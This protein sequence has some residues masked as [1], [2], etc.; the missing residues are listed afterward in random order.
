MVSCLISLVNL[1]WW[2]GFRM[3]FVSAQCF[4]KLTW[5]RTAHGETLVK[6]KLSL[7]FYPKQL[8]MPRCNGNDSK[9]R[10]NVWFWK[11]R[12]GL[13][14]T[15]WPDD[16]HHRWLPMAQWLVL[17]EYH[18]Q[19]ITQLGRKGGELIKIHEAIFWVQYSGDKS[20]MGWRAESWK[21]LQFCLLWVPLRADH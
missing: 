19:Q 1:A 10:F 2:L 11:K 5:W 18:H 15:I 8:K 9:S 13:T 20:W 14:L 16:C 17:W 12:A 21:D 7:P 6:I 3:R 4:K